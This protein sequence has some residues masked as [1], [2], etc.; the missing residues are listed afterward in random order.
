LLVIGLKADFWL[1]SGM[2]TTPVLDG[3]WV[4]TW[5]SIRLS[6]QLLITY[7]DVIQVGYQS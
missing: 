4:L 2:Y 5:L 1:V 6:T 3:Y 7:L